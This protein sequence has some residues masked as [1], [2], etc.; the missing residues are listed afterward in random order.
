MAPILAFK[1]AG[2]E[3]SVMSIA[4]GKIPL[5]EAS[6]GAPYRTEEVDTFLAGGML[7]FTTAPSLHAQSVCSQ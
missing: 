3:V 4:G 2:L 1:D 7:L 6:M 5:D